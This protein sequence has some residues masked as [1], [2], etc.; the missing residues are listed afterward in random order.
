[1]KLL[2]VDDQST[3]V[4]GLLH[5]TNWAEMG[6]TVVDTALNAVDAKASLLR[7]E[8]E[9]MLCD[10]EMPMESGLDLLDWL[11]QR[12]MTTRCIFLTAH[13]E[14]RYAQE[15]LRLGGFDYIMQPAPY[16]QVA[17]AVSR[18]LEDVKEE[19]AALEMLGCPDAAAALEARRGA[20]GAEPAEHGSGKYEQRGVH[21]AAGAQCNGGD[22]C[23]AVSR[24]GAAKPGGGAAGGRLYHP[25][26][27][28]SAKC[29]CAIYPLRG[30]LLSGGAAAL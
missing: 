26:A 18:A 25:A 10:I 7:Q 4:Q 1:M 24:S 16:E 23:G 13:A 29:V 5:C 19:R 3:V 27:E 21:A 8:A 9:V 14:F 20:V 22:P 30:G 17:D 2:I 28:L 6:F 11:R 12:G 15:A